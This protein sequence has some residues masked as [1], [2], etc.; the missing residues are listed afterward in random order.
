VVVWLGAR[1]VFCDVGLEDFS[2]TPEA[3][4]RAVTR[5]TRAVMPVHPFGLVADVP[6]IRAA[7]SR[8][9][10]RK[11]PALVEDAACALGSSLR[12]RAAGPM[13][14]AGCFSF[15]PRKILTTGEGLEDTASGP[16]PIA[17][18][19]TQDGGSEGFRM[20]RPGSTTG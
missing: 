20:D 11:R 4:A 10:R 9:A 17:A 6:A 18:L 2:A 3:F 15:H 5:R 1:P 12:G 13:G 19:R 8:T 14:D 16:R 7:V